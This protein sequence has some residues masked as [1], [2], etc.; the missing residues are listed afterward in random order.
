MHYNTR[1]YSSLSHMTVTRATNATCKQRHQ[2]LCSSNRATPCGHQYLQLQHPKKSPRVT[3]L[4]ASMGRLA[5]NRATGVSRASCVSAT[6]APPALLE[7]PGTAGPFGFPPLAFWASSISTFVSCPRSYFSLHLPHC[8]F[9]S[10]T[11]S[12]MVYQS[13]K[14]RVLSPPSPKTLWHGDI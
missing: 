13:P 14:H 8:F 1:R 3:S 6:M 7:L 11:V 4:D 10:S 2:D 9:D 5:Y 12:G